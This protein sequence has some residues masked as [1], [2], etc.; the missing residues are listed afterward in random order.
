MGLGNKFGN[1]GINQG[2]T[3]DPGSVRRAFTDLVNEIAA[4]ADNFAGIIAGAGMPTR[5]AQADSE[6]ATRK[7]VERYG[8]DYLEMME[9]A[10][11]LGG[12]VLATMVA[13]GSLEG[14]SAMALIVG[15]ISQ[16]FLVGHRMGMAAKTELED[17][18]HPMDL[19]MTIRLKEQQ[20]RLLAE[21]VMDW[22]QRF[23]ADLPDA[24][25]EV[26]MGVASEF[27]R[28]GEAIKMKLIEKYGTEE[29]N[30]LAGEWMDLH[31]EG[32][33]PEGWGS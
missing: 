24:Q 15:A 29:A 4:E 28:N 18:E 14:T 31:P 8:I 11:G 32:N 6:Q 17:G 19:A 22:S 16:S 26:M 21:I 25:S 3:G 9:M 7:V 13:E 27:I 12:T 1:G 23:G 5:E 20:H 33:L 10:A 2:G 30:R